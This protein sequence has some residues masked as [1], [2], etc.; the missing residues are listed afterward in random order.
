MA[1]SKTVQEGKAEP[2]KPVLHSRGG[3]PYIYGY[4]RVSDSERQRNSDVVQEEA[5]DKR[6]ALGDIK[7]TYVG[8]LVDYIST[9]NTPFDQRNNGA[10][11]LRNI[12]K[13]D[14]VIVVK[15]DRFGRTVGQMTEAVEKLYDLG[16]AVYILN[17]NGQPLP[18]NSTAGRFMVS[19][20]GA[21]ARL[22]NDL[23]RERITETL[24]YRKAHGLVYTRIIPFGM[25]RMDQPHRKIWVE[26]PE[27]IE[28]LK[29]FKR[30][31]D[32]GM[33]YAKIGQWSL[34]NGLKDQNGYNW[35]HL[36]TNG[37]FIRIN[38]PTKIR[39]AIAWLE[40]YLK[41]AGTVKT[42]PMS[43]WGSA[44]ESPPSDASAALPES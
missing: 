7:G 3:P 30:M 6:A 42:A 29:K 22:E 20:M 11:L 36:M 40:E 41:D 15:F 4:I 24:R 35:T 32:L 26:D 21:A 39:K 16:A 33:S 10:W 37:H 13:G 27:Q 43:N 5:I 17:Y 12:R 28:L 14:S 31:H 44:S 9:I 2:P 38:D 34:D 18:V 25:R 8:C 19:I 23:R 1:C